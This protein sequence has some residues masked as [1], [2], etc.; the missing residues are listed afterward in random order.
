MRALCSSRTRRAGTR[1]RRGAFDV[2]ALVQPLFARFVHHAPPAQPQRLP[3]C[4][5]VQPAVC[6]ARPCG[7]QPLRA[8]LT[9]CAPTSPS[10]CS[11]HRRRS[12]LYGVLA[13]LGLGAS[14]CSRLW[15]AYHIGVRVC[16]LVRRLHR[17]GCRGWFAGCRDPVRSSARACWLVVCV[18]TE[19]RRPRRL[20]VP[21]R[22]LRGLLRCLRG[23]GHLYHV[24]RGLSLQQLHLPRSQLNGRACDVVCS[25]IYLPVSAPLSLPPAS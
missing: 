12:C 5:E 1:L 4:T 23:A 6:F 8:L 9:P 15:A 21:P 2:Q 22:G 13:C 14:L 3:R 18:P 11:Q 24:P 16:A 7:P 10:C 25:F 19:R 20:R 17:A